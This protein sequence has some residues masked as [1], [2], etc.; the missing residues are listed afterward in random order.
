MSEG[1]R[2]GE[3]MVLT[4]RVSFLRLSVCLRMGKSWRKVI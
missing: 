3:V 1:G 2:G 4:V